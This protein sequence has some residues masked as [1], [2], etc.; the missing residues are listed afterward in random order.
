ML[1]VLKPV[2]KL[3]T[4][5]VFQFDVRSLHQFPCQ[6]I[7][8]SMS[9]IIENYWGVLYLPFSLFSFIIA[10]QTA[11]ELQAG[12]FI[13]L[14]TITTSDSFNIN[15]MKSVQ[16]FSNIRTLLLLTCEASPKSS[17]IDTIKTFQNDG[18]WMNILDI[19]N[20]T[21][22][23]VVNFK[24]FFLRLSSSHIVVCNLTCHQTIKFLTEISKLK[25]FH[26][27][28]NWLLFS[29]KLEYAESVLRNEN[30]N[31]DAE[32]TLVVPENQK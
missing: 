6:I 7:S 26:G 1:V 18:T 25:M 12:H 21:D 13:L 16:T 28:R 24:H 10:I 27:E 9:S 20:G 23:S 29:D 17:F 15:L 30:I 8:F 2:G 19:S 5:I 3:F 22:I 31:S 14:L 32:I 11:M 4:K